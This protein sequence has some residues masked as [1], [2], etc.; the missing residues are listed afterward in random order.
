MKLLPDGMYGRMYLM[1]DAGGGGR[2]IP[3]MDKAGGG[4]R[5]GETARSQAKAKH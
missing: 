4:K 3:Y 2:T 5:H 1:H